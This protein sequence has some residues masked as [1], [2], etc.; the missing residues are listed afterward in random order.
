M[1]KQNSN[2][3]NNET[4][5][6]SKAQHTTSARPDDEPRTK[7]SSKFGFV[8]FLIALLGLAGIA[9]WYWGDI[10]TLTGGQQGTEEVASDEEM[11]N[12]TYPAVVA[13]VN[14]T[15]LSGVDLQENIVQAKQQAKQQGVDL[16]DP[17]VQAQIEEQA[18]TGLIHAALLLQVARDSDI[19]IADEDIATELSILEAQLGGAEA[20][21][22]QLEALDTT[23]E[24]LRASIREQL[25]VNAYLEQVIGASEITVSDGE[26]S[27]FYDSLVSQNQGQELPSLE[28]FAPQLQ[29]QLL[30]QK[31]QEAI[32]VYLQELRANADVEI[33]I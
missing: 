14:G 29:Q 7:K 11:T 6:T 19:D 2:N 4:T 22:A 15:E 26:I 16:S 8:T 9:W 3:S 24:E 5:T 25:L 18:L 28:E 31:Q 1:P 32:V 33:L 21:Q 30:L 20:M 13:R 17:S 23:K 10:S 27:A 12:K